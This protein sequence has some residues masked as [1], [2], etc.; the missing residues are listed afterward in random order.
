[1]DPYKGIAGVKNGYTTHAGNT[2]TGVAERNGKVLLVTVMNPSA[3]ESHAV[4]KRG[5]QAARL[6]LRRERQGDPGR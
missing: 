6:G 4:Y 2:F 3:E 5:R 1:M